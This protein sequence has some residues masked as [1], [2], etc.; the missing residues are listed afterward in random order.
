MIFKL[1]ETAERSWQNQFARSQAQ[2]AA[3]CPLPSPRFGDSSRRPLLWA[4]AGLLPQM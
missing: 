3:A 4:P 2:A 1:A